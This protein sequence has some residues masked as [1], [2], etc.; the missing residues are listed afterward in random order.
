MKV[1]GGKEF[2]CGETMTEGD[3]TEK[4]RI[5]E[6]GESGCEE[7]REWSSKCDL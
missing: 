2:W 4:R 3:L 6:V 1:P 7:R 5:E